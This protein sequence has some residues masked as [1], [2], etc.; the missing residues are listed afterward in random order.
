[1][2]VGEVASILE[3]IAAV[4]VVIAILFT[5]GS[6]IAQKI[7]YCLHLFD[8]PATVVIFILVLAALIGATGE[9]IEPGSMNAIRHMR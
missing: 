1:M 5:I 8:E 6:L 3:V 9:L 2:T 4:L 7:G